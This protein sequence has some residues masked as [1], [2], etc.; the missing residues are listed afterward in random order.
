M[1][2]KKVQDIFE[3]L[4]AESPILAG[5]A[6]AK[7]IYAPGDTR[8]LTNEE[9][10]ALARQGNIC[11]D[12]GRIRVTASFNPRPV[13]GNTLVGACVLG[14]FSG[15]PVE[16]QQGLW[17]PSGVYRSTLVES[18]I[19]D[20]CLVYECGAVANYIVASNA[21][22]HQSRLVSRGEPQFGN[23]QII[24]VGLETGGRNIVNFAE[25]PF[26]L[27]VAIAM[28]RS[29]REFLTACEE[30]AAQYREKASFGK[31]V[32]LAG[33]IVRNGSMVVDSCIGSWAI[34][35]GAAMIENATVFGGAQEL[36]FVGEGSIVRESCVQWGCA[37]RS[38][39]IVE[40]SALLEHSYVE[41][42]G[43]V[44]A[45][46]LGPNSG[47]AEGE[48]TSSLVGPFVG[49]HHQALLI[50]ALWPEGK[51]NIGYGANVG[52]NHTGKAP[53]QEIRCGEGAFFGLGV[54]IKFPADLSES[55]YTIIATGV[56]TMPQKVR[57]P[58]SLINK[59]VRAEPELP[60]ALNELFPGWMLADN[61]YA[62]RRNEAKFSS[63]NKAKRTSIATAVFRPSIVAMLRDARD[64][65]RAVDER[66]PFYTERDIPGTGRNFISNRARRVGIQAYE[67]FIELYALEGVYACARELADN[68]ETLTVDTLYG[69]ERE[70]EFREN[71]RRVL[72][73]ERYARR[74]LDENLR[75]YAALVRQIANKTESAKERDDGRG[76]LIIA[77]YC[78]VHVP[79]SEDPFVKE[80]RAW[81]E[82]IE[83]AV[84]DILRRL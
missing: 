5:V 22:V 55:P 61:I 32:V 63:R 77:D 40:K 43:K 17:L 49:F 47:V 31:G 79:A 38:I 27:A 76:A 44:S 73:E 1:D 35:D 25:L 24:S 4:R 80:T 45:T 78:D 74:P 29:N 67:L 3:A 11:D 21:I 69:C 65:L 75:R 34:I 83:G 39:S 41:R 48:V 51:G 56:D 12:W 18:V 42:H 68:G 57:M 16:V 26:E 52:S 14:A 70:D 9:V 28:N 66:K 54:N 50:A 10:E 7:N 46:I 23:G 81:A 58:F 53:D 30:L 20:E 2:T 33:A 8:H 36:T 72:H 60:P 59:P 13:V 71:Q 15:V 84:S 6:E 62:I 19:G 37:V 82:K 64:R